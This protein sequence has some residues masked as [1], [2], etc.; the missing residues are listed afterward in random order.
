ME[1]MKTSK[2]L[3]T[4]EH[5]ALRRNMK[6]VDEMIRKRL[7]IFL[8][9][10]IAPVLT[11]NI[12]SRSSLLD[13]CK[14]ELPKLYVWGFCRGESE[15][16]LVEE[17]KLKVSMSASDEVRISVDEGKRWRAKPSSN[18]HFSSDPNH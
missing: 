11:D 16:I 9:E 13:S 4:R 1:N 2:G 14:V 17:I 7:A 5:A 3:T 12:K 6:R 15:M 18:F 8:K 10:W